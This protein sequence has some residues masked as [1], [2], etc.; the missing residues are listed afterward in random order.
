MLEE[1]Y[2]K[3]SQPSA[4]GYQQY[5]FKDPRLKELNQYS[6]QLIK[7]TIIP[8]LT[9]QVNASKRYA[10]LR[11]VYYSLILAQWFKTRYRS[12]STENRLQITGKAN[13]YL[14]LI[15][16]GEL[17]NL[18]SKE[19]YDKQDYFQQYQQSFKDGEYNLQET[20][21]SPFGQSIRRYVSGGMFFGKEVSSAIEAGKVSAKVNNNFIFAFKNNIPINVNFYL[22]SFN[23]MKVTMVKVI[24]NFALTTVSLL[25]FMPSISTAWTVENTQNKWGANQQIAVAIKQDNFSGILEIIRKEVTGN[26]LKI[27]P[28]EEADLIAV[29]K[30]DNPQIDWSS[31]LPGARIDMTGVL[32]EITAKLILLRP[33]MRVIDTQPLEIEGKKVTIYFT[34]DNNGQRLLGE[35]MAITVGSNVIIAMDSFDRRLSRIKDAARK[36]GNLLSLYKKIYPPGITDQKAMEL[37]MR[38]T[39]WHEVFHALKNRDI[40][41]G[42]FNSNYLDEKFKKY[43]VADKD[44]NLVAQEV[45]GW[46]G[47]LSGGKIAE[48]DLHFLVQYSLLDPSKY[49]NEKKDIFFSKIIIERLFADLGYTGKADIEAYRDFMLTLSNT[50]I[51][52]NSKA[53]LKEII[54]KL[55]NLDMLKYLPVPMHVFGNRSSLLLSDQEPPKKSSSSLMQASSTSSAVKEREIITKDHDGIPVTWKQVWNGGVFDEFRV[56]VNLRNVEERNNAFWIAEEILSNNKIP[57][58]TLKYLISGSPRYLENPD[59]S[60]FVCYFKTVNDALQFVRLFQSDKRYQHIQG[61]LPLTNT[62]ALNGIIMITGSPREHIR[63]NKPDAL[64]RTAEIAQEFINAGAHLYVLKKNFW[65]KKTIE[66]FNME[67]FTASFVTI[68]NAGS[69]LQELDNKKGGIAFNALPIRTEAVASSVLGSFPGVKAFQGDLEA[70]WAQI[71]QVFNAGIRPSIQRLSEYT[72]AASASPLAEEK[73]D[74]VRGLLADILRR[75]EEARKLTSTDPALKGLLSALETA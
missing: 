75:D 45:V 55:P 52:F 59:S 4:I 3:S 28:A 8:K 25:L 22:D 58:M 47:G 1:D 61:G 41:N 15:D 54:E 67:A 56:Y 24:K 69:P 49:P 23:S 34:R 12:Q 33:E 21:Y 35:A 32:D 9:Y 37:G 65:G 17:T 31:V 64:F 42:K 48:E 14:K 38:Q 26:G 16:S 19:P 63:D 50:E 40:R 71:Q 53:F 74:G 46:L 39:I 10:P 6:T 44:K 43:Q 7:E 73:I 72:Q 70:E 2:L 27:T 51:A 18:T 20:V 29:L 13:N 66:R 62:I 30:S 11:Q 36:G 5:E 68:K 57:D 60:K